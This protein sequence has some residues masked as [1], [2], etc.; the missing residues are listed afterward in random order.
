MEHT[1]EFYKLKGWELL[2]ALDDPLERDASVAQTERAAQ[3]AAQRAFVEDYRAERAEDRK[4]FK[5]ALRA[6]TEQK[7]EFIDRNA[8]QDQQIG[9][10]YYHDFGHYPRGN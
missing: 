9:E 1:P 10:L 4:D 7:A 3:V 5:E 8:K 2:C 6:L